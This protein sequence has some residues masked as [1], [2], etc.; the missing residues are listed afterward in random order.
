M[1]QKS[2]KLKGPAEKVV[3]DIRRATR[4][5]HSSEEKIRIVLEGLRGEA[6]TSTIAGRRSFSK[7]VR[8]G[9]PATPPVRRPRTR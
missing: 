1:R 2:R 8:N 5:R 9:S 6:R 3:K 4:K 7:P